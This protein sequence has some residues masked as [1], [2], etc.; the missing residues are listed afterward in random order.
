M[1]GD[2]TRGYD[3][4]IE[5]MESDDYEAYFNL[6]YGYNRAT[7]EGRSRQFTREGRVLRHVRT[8]THQLLRDRLEV[9]RVNVERARGDAAHAAVVASTWAAVS[10]YVRTIEGAPTGL[11]VILATVTALSILRAFTRLRWWLTYRRIPSVWEDAIEQDNHWQADMPLIIN[12]E[13]AP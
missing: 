10:L 9:S 3:A 12:E 1:M 7:I 13:D 8:V 11:K 2:S 6:E 4:L 5:E